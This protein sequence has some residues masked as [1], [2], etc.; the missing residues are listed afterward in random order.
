[1]TLVTFNPRNKGKPKK[2]K[3]HSMYLYYGTCY[4]T[5]NILWSRWVSGTQNITLNLVWAH[6][7]ILI[8]KLSKKITNPSWRPVSWWVVRCGEMLATLCLMVWTL[9]YDE[10]PVSQS[11]YLQQR[12]QEEVPTLSDSHE[13]E[14]AGRRPGLVRAEPVQT[15]MGP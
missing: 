13:A 15:S 1:M 6:I 8:S 11:L 4:G 2:K 10:P 14:D 3:K 12:T 9:T 5:C 7:K